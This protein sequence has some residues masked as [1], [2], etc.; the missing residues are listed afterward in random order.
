MIQWWRAQGIL[1][2]S[3]IDD[4]CMVAA[5]HKELIT[6]RDQV[7]APTL[8]LLGWVHEETKGQWEPSQ[9]VEVLGLV[10]NLCLGTVHIPK[11]KILH[12]IK[13]CQMQ[14]GQW[15]TQRELA[16]ITGFITSL[17]RAAPQVQLYLRS[18]FAA[19]GNPQCEWDEEVSV[20]R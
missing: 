18:T 19:M 11:A 8:H 13:T 2:F 16:R 10:L 17:A 20:T 3:Y 15:L 9:V 1:V 12:A 14:V 4:F 5:M 6:I 7:I